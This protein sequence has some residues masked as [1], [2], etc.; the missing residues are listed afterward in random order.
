MST[1]NIPIG[2]WE[3]ASIFPSG[4]VVYFAPR[5][6]FLQATARHCSHARSQV[7]TEC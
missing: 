4:S 7:M 6:R 1:I 3:H 5:I 2:A